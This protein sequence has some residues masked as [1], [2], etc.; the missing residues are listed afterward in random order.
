[1]G[2]KATPSIVLEETLLGTGSDSNLAVRELDSV[3][4]PEAQIVSIANRFSNE[5]YPVSHASDKSGKR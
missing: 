5:S 4:Y 1:M 3:V 2:C